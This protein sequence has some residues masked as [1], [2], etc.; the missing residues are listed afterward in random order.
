MSLAFAEFDPAALDPIL[1]ADQID[2]LRRFGEVLATK[3]GDVIWG[4]GER[5]PSLVVVLAGRVRA[6]DRS[7]GF[8]RTILE[9]EPGQF[10]GELSLLTGQIAWANC[11][12]VE[13]GEVLV[14]PP[15]QLRLAIETVP[16]FGDILITTLSLRRKALIAAAGNTLT[17]IGPPTS[18]SLL[19]VA[20]FVDRNRIP[21][22]WLAPDDPLAL[23]L[24]DRTEKNPYAHAWVIVRDQI[25]LANP[26]PLRV[27]HALGL[28]LGFDQAGPADL[29]VV[30]AGP[31]GLSA[32]VSA[33]SEGLNTIVVDN[34]AIGG[35]AGASSRIENYLGFPTGISGGNLAFLAE[36]QALKFGARVTVPNNAVALQQNNGLFQI[37]FE[38]G[39]SVIGRSVIVAT[40]ARYR[41]PDLPG[42]STLSG[43]FYAATELEA[44]FCNGDP[45]VVMGGGNSA[46]QAAMFL[47][48]SSSTV[49]LVHRGDDL[50]SSMSQ[51]LISRLHKAENVELHL[52]S[53]ITRL[54]GEQRV[55]SVVV[56]NRTGERCELASSAL[57]VMIGTEPC[58]GW[59]R[60]T[61]A[62]DAE[63]FVMTGP[64]LG[65][66]TSGRPRAAFETSLPGVYAVGDVRSG[67]TKRVASAVGEGSVV[68]SA[69]HRYLASTPAPDERA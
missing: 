29:I 27:A 23:D 9:A 44:R 50:E 14:V 31:A 34:V 1:P 26:T 46:G 65:R 38:H 6:I 12:V 17:L 45:V 3:D 48:D 41:V 37:E 10:I 63:G 20:E 61:V 28:D 35:Q 32:A 25:A 47:A 33:A 58:T 51:Y 68:V 22:R 64:D 43:V 36:V 56:Q 52:Q 30:G 55:G 67:S 8:D 49:H 40:G 69:I 66:V 42:A 2:L 7:D 4:A 53:T 15:D 21:F 13:G 57:F 11:V 60:G 59:L 5:R 54:H 19:R 18:P 39:R 16:A 24:L 62:L